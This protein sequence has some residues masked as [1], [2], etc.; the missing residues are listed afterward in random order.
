MTT[1]GGVRRYII[2][3]LVATVEAVY[4]KADSFVLERSY[5]F[6]DMTKDQDTLAPS[7]T[8]QPHLWSLQSMTCRLTV[9]S[10]SLYSCIGKRRVFID[11]WQMIAWLVWT[12]DIAFA[13]GEDGLSFEGDATDAFM[14]TYGELRSPFNLKEI[15]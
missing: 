8:D 9:S 4:S 10:V 11:I 1:S 15:I 6:P 14:M 5:Q 2:L 7:S 13:P 3:T 12:L